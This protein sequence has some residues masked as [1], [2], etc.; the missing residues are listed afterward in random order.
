MRALRRYTRP[1]RKAISRPL[2]PAVWCVI[3][4]VVHAWALLVWPTCRK[5]ARGL[6]E[7]DAALAEGK[8]VALAIYHESVLPALLIARGRPLLTVASRSDSGEM[9]ARVITHFGLDVARGGSSR[10]RSRRTPVVQQVIAFMKQRPRTIAAITVDGSS[11]PRRQAKPGVLEVARATGSP[12]YLAHVHAAPCL[13]LPSWD[14]TILPL[15]F[16]RVTTVITGPM[17]VPP[18]PTAEQFDALK[19]ELQRRLDETAA[20]AEGA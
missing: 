15:P 9:I 4:W 18:R 10:G 2:L 5:R 19:A 17:H 8:G 20:A 3:P 7:L 11:G 1:V 16:C 13:R 6:N 14:R 12:L